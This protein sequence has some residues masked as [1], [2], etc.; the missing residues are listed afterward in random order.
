MKYY[1][2]VK[3]GLLET[4]EDNEKIKKKETCIILFSDGTKYE[5]EIHSNKILGE[6]KYYFLVEQSIVGIY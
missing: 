6:G 4:K 5:G 1:G 2:P 3:N